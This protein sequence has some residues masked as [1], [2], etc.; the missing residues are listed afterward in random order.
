MLTNEYHKHMKKIATWLEEVTTTH[1]EATK[2]PIIS[3]NFVFLFISGLM[4]AP[5]IIGLFSISIEVLLLVCMQA[6]LCILISDLVTYDADFV[7]LLL[8]YICHLIWEIMIFR[9]R[10][11]S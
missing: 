8:N 3:W 1:H 9:G 10:T 5:V 11:P 6:F 2:I 4:F 7:K